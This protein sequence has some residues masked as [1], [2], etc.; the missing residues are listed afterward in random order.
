MGTPQPSV[1]VAVDALQIRPCTTLEELAAC[2]AVQ[3]QVSGYSELDFVPKEI[4]V[5]AGKV[6]GHVLG[7]Y[8]AG[9]LVGFVAASPGLRSGRVFLHSLL[10]ALLPAYD[11]WEVQRQLKLAQ[12]DD[13][14]ARGV[15][16]L[17]WTFDPLALSQARFYLEE[18]GVI[19]RRFEPNL[20]G[21]ASV[22]GTTG[23]PTDRL[24]AEWW[25]RAPRVERLLRGHRD[26]DSH[27]TVRI[28]LPATI[29]QLRHT[30][31]AEAERIQTDAGRQFESWLEAGYAVTGF[32]LTPDV[33]TYLL[34]PYT[35]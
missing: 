32:E 3:R 27:G 17:E 28:E 24:V 8:D 30:D 29:S 11:R 26:R 25:L 20:Y 7:A 14:L 35:G 5:V 1:R 2:A 15:E 22:R 9:N 21:R 6:G 4:L 13:A 18:L 31:P 12:R 34:E 16:L 10:M 23:L 19:V 33:G